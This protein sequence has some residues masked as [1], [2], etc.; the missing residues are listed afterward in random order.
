MSSL[1]SGDGRNTIIHNGLSDVF[2]LAAEPFARA[3]TGIIDFFC[4][5]V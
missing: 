1:P 5:F 3:L 4:F 2:I